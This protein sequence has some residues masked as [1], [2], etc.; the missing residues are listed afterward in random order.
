MPLRED[1]P[2][3]DQLDAVMARLNTDSAR[4]VS[5]RQRIDPRLAMAFTQLSHSCRPSVLCALPTLGS[6]M[7][8]W[9][10]APFRFR[11]CF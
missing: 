3:A 2:L 6:Q 8:R 10:R 7:Y 11:N 5:F 4:L 1:G 9:N